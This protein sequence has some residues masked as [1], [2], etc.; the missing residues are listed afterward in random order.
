[1][2]DEFLD[3]MD[4]ETTM[5]AYLN[6]QLK[7]QALTDFENALK[8]H[9]PLAEEVLLRKQLR[10]MFENQSALQAI[11]NMKTWM[12]E[13]PVPVQPTTLGARWY[14]TLTRHWIWSVGMS[15][16]LMG[17][18]GWAVRDYRLNALAKEAFTHYETHS[19]GSIADSLLQQGM[20]AYNQHQYQSA[21]E[22][23]TTYL[24][25]KQHDLDLEVQLYLGVSFLAKGESAAALQQLIV[26]ESIIQVD[27]LKYLQTP[28]R[29]YLGLAYLRLGQKAK[30]I[31][32]LR[33]LPDLPV[34]QAL[35][36]S[37]E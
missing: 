10:A 27:Y 24:R 25:T 37:L 17:A 22:S 8:R 14:A 11:H 26:F 15:L 4:D 18:G 31:A 35:L 32:I 9:K 21:I 3:Y 30:A 29:W 1:M 6:G 16:F 20:N 13:H 33:Q 36:K 23:L 19:S 34:A 2:A 5:L 7:G 28:G 12:T